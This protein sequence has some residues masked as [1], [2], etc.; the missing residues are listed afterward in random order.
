MSVAPGGGA[1]STLITTLV[2]LAAGLAA[3][4]W[5]GAGAIEAQSPAFD[6]PLQLH[7]GRAWWTTGDLGVNGRHHP[8][9]PAL[10]AATA[11][12]GS[13]ARLPYGEQE[14]PDWRDPAV[15]YG[16]SA[17]FVHVNG[18]EAAPDRIIDRGRV[19]V[20]TVS[21]LFLLAFE[22]PGL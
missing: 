1:R 6:E 2:L 13:G 17:A 15:Q 18:T 9:L 3:H 10:L 11:L 14:P 8:P 12:W 19:A 20:L 4:A 16:L 21:C 22:S 7:V 5:L